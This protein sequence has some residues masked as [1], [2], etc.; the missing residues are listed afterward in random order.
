LFQEVSQIPNLGERLTSKGAL[1]EPAQEYELSPSWPD[2]RLIKTRLKGRD[3]LPQIVH[4]LVFAAIGLPLCIKLLA[5]RPLPEPKTTVLLIVLGLISYHLPVTMPSS[6]QFNPGF[7]LLMSALY[8][9]GISA[10]LLV[11]IPSM[12]L[13]FFTKKHGLLTACST[14]ASLRYVFT[15]PNLLP[16]KQAGNLGFLQ[17]TNPS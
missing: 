5:T 8:V 3:A 15:Q 13:Y 4:F 12:L 11:V 16:C 10:C 7:P 2:S 6:V 1:E 9:H 17:T 14:Q